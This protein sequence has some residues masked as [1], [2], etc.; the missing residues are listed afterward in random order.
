MT[1]ALA[2]PLALLA[3]FLTGVVGLL[4]LEGQRRRRFQRA[5]EIRWLREGRVIA[6][7]SRR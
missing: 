5:L 2:I 1:L 3:S 7:R 6:L 4:L